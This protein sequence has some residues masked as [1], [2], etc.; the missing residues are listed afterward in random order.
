MLLWILEV[1]LL[2]LVFIFVVHHLIRFFMTNLTVPRTKDLVYR[3]AQS[4]DDIYKLIG[5]N[6]NRDP[7]EEDDILAANTRFNAR[8]S[9][10]SASLSSSTSSSSTP[11]DMKSELKNFLKKQWSPESSSNNNNSNS[12]NGDWAWAG[13]D[14]SDSFSV[15]SLHSSAF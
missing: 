3:P 7:D 13:A 1:V 10:S 5:R 6:Q 2:S 15:T 8:R 11:Q 14:N 9:S 12:N 4:Y